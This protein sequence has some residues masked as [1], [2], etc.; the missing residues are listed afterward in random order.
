MWKIS[1]RD[2]YHKVYTNLWLL[3]L[4]EGKVLEAL[5]TVEEGRAQALNDLLKVTYAWNN[6]W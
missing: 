6:R 3:L 1:L 2:T 5:V 4:K